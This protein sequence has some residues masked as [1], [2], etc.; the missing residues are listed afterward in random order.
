MCLYS[1][2]EPP[3]P[4]GAAQY[5]PLVNVEPVVPTFLGENLMPIPGADLI[6]DD[7]VGLSASPSCMRHNNRRARA[8]TRL[9]E[10]SIG[11]I[12]L[13]IAIAVVDVM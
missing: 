2:S 13:Q 1:S 7:P 10:P 12:A 8:F 9:A 6:T 3:Q 4:D 5:L 11:R